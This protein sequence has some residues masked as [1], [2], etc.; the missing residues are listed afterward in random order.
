ISYAL[1]TNSA[2]VP[3][4]VVCVCVSGIMISTNDGFTEHFALMFAMI[5]CMFVLNVAGVQLNSDPKSLTP[6]EIVT[7]CGS[8]QNP[9]DMTSVSPDEV[10]GPTLWTLFNAPSM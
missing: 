2:H 1:V 7:R 10:Q 6:S 4:G 8:K 3:C 9:D 5:V